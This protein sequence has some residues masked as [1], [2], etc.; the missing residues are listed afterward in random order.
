MREGLCKVGLKKQGHRSIEKLVLVCGRAVISRRE[1]NVGMHVDNRPPMVI[2]SQADIHRYSVAN[3]YQ[4]LARLKQFHL[5]LF[6]T[7]NHYYH[8]YIIG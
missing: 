5:L 6:F 1:R 4:R 8:M 7:A 3:I 2:H